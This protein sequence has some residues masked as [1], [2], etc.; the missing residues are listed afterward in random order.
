MFRYLFLII[1]CLFSVSL[2]SF[3]DEVPYEPLSDKWLPLLDKATMKMKAN[4][5]G[6]RTWQG[7]VLYKRKQPA[8][9]WVDD[10]EIVFY[11]D[12]VHSRRLIIT[13][14]IKTEIEG[15]EQPLDIIG[16]FIDADKYYEYRTRNH[17]GI[18]PIP[19]GKRIRLEDVK[20]GNVPEFKESFLYG[21]L[22][23]DMYSN[24]RF[25]YHNLKD[26]F[27]PFVVLL[28]V[29]EENAG[30][31]SMCH[32]LSQ[33]IRQK[34]SHQ[35]TIL[36]KEENSKIHISFKRLQDANPN[37]YIYDM[38]LGGNG[39]YSKILCFGSAQIRNVE[40]EKIKEYFV[41]KKVDYKLR[42]EIHETIE[43][44]SQKINEPITDE[45][46]RVQTMGVKR[47]DSF[48]DERTKTLSTVDNIDFL[49]HEP[50]VYLPRK[51]FNYT[52]FILIA[53]GLLLIL[54]AIFMK[55]RQWSKSKTKREQTNE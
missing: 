6:I 12:R 4:M 9:K 26:N 10:M 33:I 36:L 8:G 37:I 16:L 21:Q 41:P 46:F 22:R 31:G 23:V 2:Y 18:I 35:C 50:I 19:G 55:W 44:V 52:R 48:F 28:D 45:V 17:D 13:K 30:V 34:P 24:F 53:L 15:R 40:F 42:E 32:Y 27:N 38:S 49:R 14:H 11:V 7:K 39:I 47:G 29:R 54:I 51:S 43:F 20:Q 3:A 5:E 25:S 1:I